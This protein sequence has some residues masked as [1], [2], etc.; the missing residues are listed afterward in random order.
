MGGGTSFARAALGAT[1]GEVVDGSGWADALV[2]SDWLK[3]FVNQ[4]IGSVVQND[5]AASAICTAL[6]GAAGSATLARAADRCCAA[7]AEVVGGG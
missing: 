7:R 6:T 4:V 1:F 2:G 5:G 3:E